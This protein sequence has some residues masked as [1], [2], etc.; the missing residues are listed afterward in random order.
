MR[1]SILQTELARRAAISPGDLVF[2]DTIRSGRVP[3]RVLSA[4]RVADGDGLGRSRRLTLK[5]T[6]ARYAYPR[7]LVFTAHNGAFVQAR[8]AIR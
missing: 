8:G 2:Y 4:E 1:V 6:G 3:C 5:V 7:G